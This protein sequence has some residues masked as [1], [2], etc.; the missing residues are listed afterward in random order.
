[1]AVSGISHNEQLQQLVKPHILP[2]TKH[3][4]VL[5]IYE[6]PAMDGVI[7]FIEDTEMRDYFLVKYDFRQE[8]VIR[9]ELS[10]LDE[11]KKIT[12]NFIYILGESPILALTMLGNRLFVL[13]S[14]RSQ[15][16]NVKISI[17]LDFAGNVLYKRYLNQDN[18]HDDLISIYAFSPTSFK[19]GY[20]E[21]GE[22]LVNARKGDNKKQIKYK[23]HDIES[24]DSPKLSYV[25]TTNQNHQLYIHKRLAKGRHYFHGNISDIHH[26]LPGNFLCETPL[27]YLVLISDKNINK[28]EIKLLDKRN[29]Q[30]IKEKKYPP[31]M[32]WPIV[33]QYQLDGKIAMA[34]CND[35]IALLDND[36]NLLTQSRFQIHYQGFFNKNNLLVSDFE[37]DSSLVYAVY[38]DP[39]GFFSKR[40]DLVLKEKDKLLKEYFSCLLGLF[41]L[42]LMRIMFDYNILDFCFML[43]EAVNDAVLGA[44][45]ESKPVRSCIFL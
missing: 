24:K 7:A 40:R 39:I 1:M 9:T 8:G 14:G 38:F 41:Q 4:R 30:V 6:S 20:I 32:S 31:T 22:W 21:K 29:L 2:V 36:L 16:A 11:I 42:P 34:D 19:C 37:R 5:S 35:N 12:E 43:D 17:V 10:H 33:A 27:G 23:V 25:Q 15:N 26:G 44:P 28:Y 45:N 3:E 18:D 13:I